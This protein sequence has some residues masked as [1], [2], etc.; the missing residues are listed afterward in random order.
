MNDEK[1]LSSHTDDLASFT[2]KLMQGSREDKLFAIVL[3][4]INA[5]KMNL[6]LIKTHL[7]I[8]NER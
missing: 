7:G 1:A 6:E 8:K 3:A 4:E 2:D 5:L